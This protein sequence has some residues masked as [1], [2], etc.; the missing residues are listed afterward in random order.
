VDVRLISATNRD[1]G[2]GHLRLDLVDRLGVFQV[3]VPPLRE[4]RE[5]IPG[6]AQ[7]IYREE[8]QQL[9]EREPYPED[10]PDAVVSRLVEE[11]WPGNIRQ[12]QNALRCL[13]TFNADGQLLGNDSEGQEAAINF[14]IEQAGGQ[15]TAASSASV[16]RLPPGISLPEF[17]RRERAEYIESALALSAGNSA[18]AARLLGISRQAIQKYLSERTEEE[19]S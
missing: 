17:Q 2:A 4:R 19:N 6:L 11:Q 3:R 9:L 8:V 13:V 16:K 1:L 15:Q 14:A 10:L 7:Q 12:L 5:D 18:K